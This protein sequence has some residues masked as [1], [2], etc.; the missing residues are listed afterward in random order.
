ML[1]SSGQNGVVR[2]A[3]DHVEHNIVHVTHTIYSTHVIR[4]LKARWRVSPEPLQLGE[5]PAWV[6][7]ACK[8][9][10]EQIMASAKV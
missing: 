8:S 4:N 7:V 10:L 3:V 6:D 2:V 5:R 1:S 9:T